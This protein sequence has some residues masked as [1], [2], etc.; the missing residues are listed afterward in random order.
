MV[1][2]EI[3]YHDLVDICRHKTKQWYAYNHVSFCNKK[4]VHYI[5]SILDDLK[6]LFLEKNHRQEGNVLEEED[7]TCTSRCLC[8]TQFTH[9]REFFS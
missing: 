2:K 5:E 3:Q 1:G 7:L 6:T 4:E 9:D 8:Y